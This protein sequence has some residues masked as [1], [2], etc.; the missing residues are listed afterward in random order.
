MNP[1]KFQYELILIEEQLKNGKLTPFKR[2]YYKCRA[3]HLSSVLNGDDP[4][5]LLALRNIPDEPG[6]IKKRKLKNGSNG[7]NSNGGRGTK[8]V[9]P[10]SDIRN[11]VLNGFKELGVSKLFN[12]TKLPTS[13]LSKIKK[14]NP[15]AEYAIEGYREKLKALEKEEV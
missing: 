3:D 13:C 5:S 9:L 6:S 7:V 12:V 4:K 8:S 1:Q 11:A 10:P 15:I 2:G 14:N